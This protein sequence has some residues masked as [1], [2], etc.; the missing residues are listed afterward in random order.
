MSV[1]RKTKKSVCFMLCRLEGVPEQAASMKAS[2]KGPTRREQ[3]LPNGKSAVF[4]E[5][6]RSKQL[7]RRLLI[8][9]S[10]K[11]DENPSAFGHFFITW[12]YQ[13]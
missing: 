5:S 3:E 6:R 7:S 1:E 10:D 12:N 13:T 11:T 8:K 2:F 9:V 4:A